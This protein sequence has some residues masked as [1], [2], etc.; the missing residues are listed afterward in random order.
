MVVWQA[1]RYALDP[2][3][4]QRGRLASHAG[5]ARY[6]YNLGLQWLKTS[7]E[8]NRKGVCALPPGAVE[9][10]KRWNRWKK[11]PNNGVSWWS[12]NSKCVY[13]EAFV[14]LERATKTFFVSRSGKR[15]GPRL[16]FPRFK[17]KGKSRDH[18][19]LTGEIHVGT[20]WVQLPKLGTLRIS[21]SPAQLLR[22]LT[23]GTARIT[24]ASVSR[25]AQRWYVSFRVQRKRRSAK[26]RSGN[27][28]VGLDVGINALVTL[29]TGEVFA[30]P[31]ALRSSLRRLRRLSKAHSRKK[32][33]SANRRRS[34]QVLARCHARIAHVRRD[35]LHKLSTHLA[36][37]HGQIVIEDLNVRAMLRNRR[38]A[39]SIADASWGELTSMLEYK[40]RWYGAKLIRADRFFASSKTCSSC[41]YRK[42]TLALAERTFSCENCGTAQDRDLNAAVNLA[43]WPEVAGS[44]PETRNACRGDVR[45]GS[46]RA[47]LDEAGTERP[48]LASGSEPIAR[49]V[50]FSRGLDGRA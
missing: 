41:G 16:G 49:A 8:Q 14:D 9:M 42:E 26:A 35:G 7:L 4:R 31:R 46:R 28:V 15:P 50:A 1:Y 22:H 39:R 48:T 2:N 11:D 23:D 20:S 37:S 44:A 25:E 3:D 47:V 38:L 45:P 18:F 30:P 12:D 10:H 6:A 17:R 32:M 24:A 29:S 43:H 33:H 21:E 27:D 5:G 34:A 19:R 40:C 13:Q 36:K